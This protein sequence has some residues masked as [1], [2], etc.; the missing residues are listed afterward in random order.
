MMAAM[1]RAGRIMAQSCVL[2]GGQRRL[3]QGPGQPRVRVLP[4]SMSTTAPKGG[5]RTMERAGRMEA[6]REALAEEKPAMEVRAGTAK[7][8][9][10]ENC[11]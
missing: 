8:S 5:E 11:A 9:S 10:G 3:S 7:A 6:P 2:P 4:S 1:P